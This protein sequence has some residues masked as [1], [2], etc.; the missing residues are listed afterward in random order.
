MTKWWN[1]AAGLL[2]AGA[3]VA[4]TGVTALAAETPSTPNRAE[5]AETRES[6]QGLRKLREQIRQ[7]RE[8]IAKEREELQQHGATIRELVARLKE[9][10]DKNRVQLEKARVELRALRLIRGDIMQVNERIEESLAALKA[11][12]EAR[13]LDALAREGVHLLSLLETKLDLFKAA[14]QAAVRAIAHLQA[15]E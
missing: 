1:K 10:P 13:D 4:G 15:A 14:N 2:L 5:S 11:A 9:E 6:L 3:I 8:K 7:T 12:R